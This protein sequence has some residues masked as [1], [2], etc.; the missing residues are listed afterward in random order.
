MLPRP[1]RFSSPLQRDLAVGGTVGAAVCALAVVA[2]ITIGPTLGH[3]LPQAPQGQAVPDV[4]SLPRVEHPALVKA[5]PAPR[6]RSRDRG[7]RA[8]VA[9]PSATSVA[10]PTVRREP[11]LP[12]TPGLPAPGAGPVGVTPSGPGGVSVPGPAVSSPSVP[13]TVVPAPSGDEPVAVPVPV[14]AAG[15]TT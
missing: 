11:A 15:A 14:P 12:G 13:V 10:Q 6:R 8:R 9:G 3:K 7:A 2:G 1:F 5:E 4:L